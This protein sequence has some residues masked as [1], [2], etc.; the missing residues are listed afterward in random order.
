MRTVTPRGQRLAPASSPPLHILPTAYIYLPFLPE[1]FSPAPII[2]HQRRC[3]AAASPSPHLYRLPIA[4]LA[5][6]RNLGRASLS[7]SPHIEAGPDDHDGS[8]GASRFLSNMLHPVRSSHSAWKTDSPWLPRL[9]FYSTNSTPV[10]AV[11]SLS[12]ERRHPKG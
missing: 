1:A 7:P 12:L 11:T 2:M 10:S 4:R 6:S 5:I 9:P 8:L 3:P